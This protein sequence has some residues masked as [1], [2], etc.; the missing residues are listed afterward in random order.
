MQPK[1]DLR[2]IATFTRAFRE[3]LGLTQDQLAEKLSTNR[4]VIAHLEQN[5]RVPP[6]E[7]L[8]SL[9]NFLEIPRE[10]WEGLTGELTHFRLEFEDALGELTGMPASLDEHPPE[11]IRT[12]EENL[13]ELFGCHFSERATLDLFNSLLV[14]YGIAPISPE[15]F[16]RYFSARAFADLSAFRNAIERYQLDAIRLYSTLEQ[17]FQSLA[18]GDIAE[19]L[20]PLNR[21]PIETYTARLDW[22]VIK[23]IAD[24]RLSDLGY[25]SAAKV[26]KENDERQLLHRELNEL[27]DLI[28]KD[29]PSSIETLSPRRRRKIDSHLRKFKSEFLHGALSPLFAPD[30]DAL[31]REA[32]RIGPKSDEQVERMAQTQ[33]I[34]LRN[35]ANYLASDYLDVYIATSMRTDADFLSVNNF[36]LDLFSRSEVA[37]LKLR[38]FNPTQSW[39]DDRIAKGL[40]EALMLKRASVTIYMAQKSDTFGKDSEASVTLGQGKPVI[41]YLPKLSFPK[42]SIDSE[43]LFAS[44]RAQLVDQLRSL[45]DFEA[46]ELDETVDIEAIVGRLLS[47]QLS[48][49]DETSFSDLLLRYWADFDLYGEAI[50][51][52]KK[53]QERREYRDWLDRVIARKTPLSAPS[54]STRK[55]AVEILVATAIGFEKRARVFREIHPLALQVILSSGVLNGILV[56]RSIP[57]CAEILAKLIENNLELELVID[58]HNYRLVEKATRSTV[59]VISR[60]KLLQNA[61]GRLYG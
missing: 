14:F 42:R 11:T 47:H 28:E 8:Q 1:Q 3:K 23:P 36:V 60:H 4:S 22:K 40:V 18:Q 46:D 26:K 31:R 35:L 19:L 9:C 59:R 53:D 2:A 61:F 54:P 12:A 10:V 45:P 37:P 49:L 41:V 13:A 17:G 29:G 34:A 30:P 55:R 20:A 56:T 58:D 7:V 52:I 48:Q 44:S 6:K 15:F 21:V 57:Q 24:D 39:V 33:D 51:R 5:R 43:V 16:N 25:I 32:E 27:A 38:Y 50:D